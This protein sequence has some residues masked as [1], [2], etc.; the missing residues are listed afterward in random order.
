MS[1]AQGIAFLSFGL[2][3]VGGGGSFPDP[4]NV[5]FGVD[6][7]NGDLGTLTSPTQSDVRQG[8]RYGGDGTQ[9][10]G[11]LYVSSSGGITTWT[12]DALEL[13]H[14]EV[15]EFGNVATYGIYTFDCILN[16]VRSGFSMT[17]TAYS[18]QADTI[19]DMLRTDAIANGLYVLAQ[20]NPQTKRPIV[21]VSNQQYEII[22]LESDDPTQ[23]S[24]RLSASQ[25]Q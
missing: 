24:I 4:Y 23:P 18:K 14:D 10:T 20:S 12:Q 15:E 11:T 2:I 3:I 25:K 5:R 8:V 7:G 13:W 22:K 17:L 1:N 6:N 21:T 16:P 9:Y 19:V